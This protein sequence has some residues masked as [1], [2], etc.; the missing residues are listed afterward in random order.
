VGHTATSIYVF[1]IVTCTYVCLIA[2]LLSTFRRHAYFRHIKTLPCFVDC[3]VTVLLTLQR[4]HVCHI[5]T[6]YFHPIAMLFVPHSATLLCLV[7]FNITMFNTLQHL[8]I[9]VTLR[10]CNKCV[11]MQH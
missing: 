11:T 7:D 3:N 1:H 4:Y 10:P 5:A 6:L 9:F 8:E 2:T